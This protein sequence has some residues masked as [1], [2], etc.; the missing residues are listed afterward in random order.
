MEKISS[1]FSAIWDIIS[2]KHQEGIFNTICLGVL[3]GLPLLVVL[4]LIFICC[5]CCWSRPGKRG[6]QPEQNKKKKK[7]KKKKDEEDLWISAQ[8]KLLQMEKRPS[9]PV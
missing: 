1:F 3:L 2:T 8:P 6:Q 5:H 4:T 7:K 9:L